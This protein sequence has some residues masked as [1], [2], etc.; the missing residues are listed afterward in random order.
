MRSY[1]QRVPGW[2]SACAVDSLRISQ[3]Q[4]ETSVNVLVKR[5]WLL[6][7][8]AA[9]AALVASFALSL[10][11]QQGEGGELKNVA[12]IGVAKY[13]KLIGDIGFLGTIGGKP[14]AGQM[15]EGAFSFFTQ[16]KGPNAI[17][18][19]KPWGVI[20]QTDGAQF[21]PVGCLPVLKAPDLL[22]VARG[23]G[24]EVKAGENGITEV[25][26]PNKKSIFVKED[27]GT[28]FIS[29]SPASLGKL[30]ANPQ[31]V[32]AKLV[33]DY[34][35]A[36]HIAVKNVPEMYR[37]FAIQAMQAG[38]QQ[39]MKQKADESDEQYAARQKLTEAQMQQMAQ[40]FNEIDSIKFGWAVDAQQ[41][42]TF[43]D[44]S[45]TAIPGSKLA[46][47]AAYQEPSTNFAGFY[48]PDAAATMTMAAKTDPKNMSEDDLAQFDTALKST[49]D[50][51]NAELE[52]KVDDAETR[53]AI[54]AAFADWADALVETI[55]TGEMD[56][57]GAL[58]LSADS[59][60]FVSGMH[61]KDA[62]KIESGFKK[63][64]AA[65]K[66]QPDFPGIQWNAAEHAGVKFHTLSIPV[67]ASE[68]KPRQLLGE[69]MDVAIGIGDGAAYFAVGKDNLNAVNKAI[70]ASASNKGK[71]VPPFELAI[72]LGPIM[73]VAAAQAN[74]GP[75]KEVTQKVADYLKSEAQGRD[76]IR[77]V[78]QVIPNG[79]KYHFEAEEGVLKAIGTAA[80]AQQEMKMR[81]A[82]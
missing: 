44:F 36:G 54:K 61:V 38:A 12:V 76:H 62:A 35:V 10:R 79:L 33:A 69:K 68:E 66:K 39:G 42:K 72:S 26:M 43:A 73:E 67:P 6:G 7:M 58:T 65:A 2:S 5:R 13:E 59:L 41:Q 71:K 3:P 81:Q 60:T 74:E 63:L 55:K 51:V 31:D 20:V 25:V 22:D 17:D 24:A 48:Q 30:P 52:K 19:T 16:G 37:Q 78:G 40:M 18:K 70:D 46:K 82:Q 49:M 27:N 14:E 15:I 53:E 4:L 34:D 23:Y 8:S 64:E 80:A 21:L 29:V 56:G 50:Q 9:C 32:L 45:Y 57:G 75:Q 1:R 28:A 47:Q 77:V 11:A